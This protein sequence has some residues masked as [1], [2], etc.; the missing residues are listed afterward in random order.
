MYETTE[1]TPDTDAEPASPTT[2][3]PAPEEES[4]E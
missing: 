4:A 1:P 2:E 3:E